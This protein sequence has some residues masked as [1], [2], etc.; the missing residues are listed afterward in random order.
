MKV[1]GWWAGRLVSDPMVVENRRTLPVTPWSRRGLLPGLEAAQKS[2]T[3]RLASCKSMWRELWTLAARAAR[4]SRRWGDP[5]EGVGQRGVL[6]GSQTRSL[7]SKGPMSCHRATTRVLPSLDLP[8]P[9]PQTPHQGH[10]LLSV[11]LWLQSLQSVPAPATERPP[12]HTHTPGASP[13]HFH[14]KTAS[15]MCWLSSPPVPDCARARTAVPGP[16][17]LGPPSSR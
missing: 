15:K 4:G 1:F 17:V 8:I 9:L 12:P 6:L 3:G 2:P 5:A 10:L 16:S 14:L 7:G 13:D 11:T